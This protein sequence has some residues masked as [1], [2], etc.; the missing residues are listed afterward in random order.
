MSFPNVCRLVNIAGNIVSSANNFYML[1]GQ[2]RKNFLR[3]ASQYRNCGRV[4][5]IGGGVKYT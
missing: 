3:H 4:N 1:L 2:Y 5:Y